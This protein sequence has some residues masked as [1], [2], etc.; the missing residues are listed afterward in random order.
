MPNSLLLSCWDFFPFGIPLSLLR[1]CCKTSLDS[2]GGIS[3]YTR[4]HPYQRVARSRSRAKRSPGPSPPN[5]KYFI[6]V[7]PETSAPGYR[8]ID[9]SFSDSSE[10]NFDI[11]HWANSSSQV[12]V[13]SVEPG[14]PD[15]VTTIV[16]QAFLLIRFVI[17]LKY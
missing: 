11:S 1:P 9:P 12:P 3:V 14:T 2:V 13:C 15:D 4:S 6:R 5:L 10:F 17:L 7:R 8:P 16:N